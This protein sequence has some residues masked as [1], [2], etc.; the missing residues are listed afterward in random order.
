MIFFVFIFVWTRLPRKTKTK[1][2]VKIG[3]VNMNTIVGYSVR[4]QHPNTHIDFQ[5]RFEKKK[6]NVFKIDYKYDFTE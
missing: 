3:N 2:K 4:I 6:V 5:N 1:T